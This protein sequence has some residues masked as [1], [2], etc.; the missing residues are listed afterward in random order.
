MRKCYRYEWPDFDLANAAVFITALILVLCGYFIGLRKYV[1]PPTQRIVFLGFISD[2]VKQTFF[3]AED[4]KKN[5]PLSENNAKYVSVKSLQRFADKA[6]SFAP[7]VLAARLFTRE[8][9]LHVSKGITSSRPVRLSDVLKE[10]LLHWRFIDSWERFLN[11][12]EEKHFSIKIIS[13]ASNSGWGENLA[14][15]TN[16]RETKD[17]WCDEVFHGSDI[18]VKEAKALC[19]TLTPFAKEIYNGR[20]N[21]Y[22]DNSNL[23]K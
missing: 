17:Y 11:W 12:K 14:L 16:P 4:K 5:L 22:A 6:V 7:V 10:E 13:D 21:A 23:I 8:V 2:S 18:A 15:L 19:H 1:L 9:N 3:L 20:V